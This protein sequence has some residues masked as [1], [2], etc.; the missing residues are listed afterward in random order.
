MEKKRKSSA[1]SQVS[2]LY[3]L[4]KKIKIENSEYG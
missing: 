1:S 4:K 2:E 3:E